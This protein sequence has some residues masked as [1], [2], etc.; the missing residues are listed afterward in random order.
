MEEMDYDKV[1]SFF[2]LFQHCIEAAALG[3]LVLAHHVPIWLDRFFK[4]IEQEMQ[5]FYL[6]ME[7]ALD[8]IVKVAFRVPMVRDWMKAN[9]ETWQ[10]LID[11]TKVNQ[12]LP[13][14]SDRNMYLTKPRSTAR[15]NNIRNKVRTQALNFYRRHGLVMIKQGQCP[16]L[17]QETDLDYY[18]LDDF[19]LV[20]DQKVMVMENRHMYI[21]TKAFIATDLDELVYIRLANKD[22][23]ST[24]EATDKGRIFIEDVWENS[25]MVSFTLFKLGF[26]D[27]SFLIGQRG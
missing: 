19:K 24:W 17:S 18:H 9:L 4:K 7:V 22:Q 1:R 5:P 8:W 26:N 15:S 25:Y 2:I 3:N 23:S 12:D 21:F 6:W 10:Y 11:W 14:A 20:K 13:L 16:D 27:F